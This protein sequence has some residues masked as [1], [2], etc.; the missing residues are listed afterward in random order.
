MKT[1]IACASGSAKGVFV[2]GVIGALIQQGLSVDVFAASSSSTIPAAF[3]AA[4]RLDELAGPA[5]WQLTADTLKERK[6]VSDS[7]T[8]IIAQLA[9]TLRQSLFLPDAR[10]FILAAS[11][12]KS[13]EE[14]EKC[15][16]LLAR[17]VGLDQLASARKKDGLWADINLATHLFD[18]QPEPRTNPLTVE[19]LADALYATTRMMHAWKAPGW[20][21]GLPYVDASYTCS[22]PAIEMAELGY[23]QVI[24]ISPE[25]GP[26]Y[27]DLYQ[28][29]VLPTEWKAAR[30]SAIQPEVDLKTIGVDYLSAVDGA[31]GKAFAA[32]K[33]AGMRFLDSS[34]IMR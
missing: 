4:G 15:Q 14:A 21:D 30:I 17:R 34:P 19:N 3:A 32:G 24:A 23:D 2:H 11:Y 27:R 9:P 10:R 28:R 8:W 25:T 1:A 20:I 18:T 12:V 7:I 26:F 5:Y 22:C 31:L 13:D 16:G 6:D 29:E 33:Q